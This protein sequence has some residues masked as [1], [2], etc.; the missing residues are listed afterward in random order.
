MGEYIPKIMGKHMNKLM[1]SKRQFI[2][3]HYSQ[4]VQLKRFYVSAINAWAKPYLL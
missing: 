2:A 3:M 1:G 4:K